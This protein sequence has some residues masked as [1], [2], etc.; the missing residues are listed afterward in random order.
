MKPN[1]PRWL[2]FVFIFIVLVGLWIS[3]AAA[4][5]PGA[6]PADSMLV[7]IPGPG[8]PTFGLIIGAILI[9]TI[10]IAGVTL[11]GLRKS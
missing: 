11:R 3:I 9:V 10:I 4:V 8:S 5:S 6:N 7:P 2:N 1:L